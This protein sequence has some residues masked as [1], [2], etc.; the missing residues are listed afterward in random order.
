MKPDL[1]LEHQIS[2]YESCEKISSW[3]IQRQNCYFQLKYCFYP[4]LNIFCFYTGYSLRRMDVLLTHSQHA[5]VKS[6]QTAIILHC[7]VEEDISRLVPSSSQKHLSLYWHICFASVGFLRTLQTSRKSVNLGL[8]PQVFSGLRIN[9][10][11]N[12]G[13]EMEVMYLAPI[14]RD[15][16]IRLSKICEAREWVRDILVLVQS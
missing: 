11:S 14:Q 5:K 6:K 8:K 3:Y 16:L 13:L 2:N 15:C 10:T 4:A 7:W 9:R 1:D 12:S